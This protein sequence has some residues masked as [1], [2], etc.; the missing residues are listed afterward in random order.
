MVT[1][2]AGFSVN[3]NIALTGGSLFLQSS[4]QRLDILSDKSSAYMTRPLLVGY[5]Q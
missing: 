4:I 3:Q 1:T 5:N 2:D